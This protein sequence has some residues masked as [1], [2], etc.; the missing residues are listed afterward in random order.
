[1]QPITT[2]QALRRLQILGLTE[3]DEPVQKALKYIERCLKGEMNIPDRTEKFR[4]WEVF[5]SL[6]FATWLKIFS[7]HNPAAIEVAKKWV[8]IIENAFLT[9]SYNHFEYLRSFYETFG[10]KAENGR[11]K[12]FVT[13][14]Q[15]S[16][17]Q[18]LLNQSTEE[19]VINHIINDETGIYYIYGKKIATLPQVFASKETSR[20][21]S[22]IEL[23]TGYDKANE[24]LK[25]V[26]DWLN[27]NQCR[28]GGWDLG[29][30]AKDG[31]NFPLSDS[32]RNE[33]SRRK[34]CTLRIE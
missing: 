34:D 31:V 3:K 29:P 28:E 20:Y 19:K 24:Y 27:I 32:W 21:L 11:G 6:T 23:L 4:D 1:M 17:I 9:D 22:A 16:I 26:V 10:V 33:Q 25:F 12:D 30:S 15:V 8:N 2:E 7:P 13:F 14:Y 18:G 5:L